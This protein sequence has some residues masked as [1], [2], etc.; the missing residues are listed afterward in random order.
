MTRPRKEREWTADSNAKRV[1]T[2]SARRAGAGWCND[3]QAQDFH[4]ADCT[5]A[6][7]VAPLVRASK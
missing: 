5:S 3:C 4:R 2:L 6:S 7:P 1:A